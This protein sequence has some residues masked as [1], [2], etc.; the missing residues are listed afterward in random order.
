MQQQLT[1][2]S[3]DLHWTSIIG[4]PIVE[5]VIVDSRNLASLLTHVVPQIPMFERLVLWYNRDDHPI[6]Q[7]IQ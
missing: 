4:E 1:V 6:R 5:G 7:P 3:F 2:V